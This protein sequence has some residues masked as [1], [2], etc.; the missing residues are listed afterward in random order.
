MADKTGTA[1]SGIVSADNANRERSSP[2]MTA[3]PTDAP[4][5]PGPAGLVNATAD[6]VRER[7]RAVQFARHYPGIR[8]H[9]SAKS[10]AMP[11]LTLKP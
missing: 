5:P 3:A 9:C 7:R 10:A 4:S 8:F 11:R 1:T 6:R 2:S